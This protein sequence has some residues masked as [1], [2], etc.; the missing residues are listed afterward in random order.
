MIA[1]T[2]DYA[3]SDAGEAFED[4]FRRT[5]MAVLRNPPIDSGLVAGI[6]QEWN[7]FFDSDAR[8]GYLAYGDRM[9][10]YFSPLPQ[11]P[12]ARDHKEF[13]HIYPGGRYPVEVSAAGRDYAA[14]AHTL[15]GELLGWLD[16]HAA[17]DV[18][19]RFPRPLAHLIERAEATVLRIQRYLPSPEASPGAPRGLAHTDINMLTLL[20]APSGPGLQ[21]SLGGRWVDVLAGPESLIVQAGEMLQA[22]S[23]D[24]YPAVLHRV[25][26]SARTAGTAAAPRM[27]MPLFVHAA[28]DAVVTAGCTAAEFRER[29]LAEL[30]DRGWVAVPGGSPSHGDRS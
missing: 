28:D 18:A 26:G 2:V 13:F 7:Q 17:A 21:V 3:A 8:L 19:V 20:S 9:D 4:S 14:A 6:Y 22:V 1:R 30:R 10:G 5:G 24:V 16:R 29:R 11:G 12:A 23:S 27:S 25:A 15:A